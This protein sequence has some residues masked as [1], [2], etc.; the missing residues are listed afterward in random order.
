MCELTGYSPQKDVFAI[1]LA[2]HHPRINLLGISTVFGNASLEYV[3]RRKRESAFWLDARCLMLDAT[4]I[5]RT[6][7]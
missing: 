3:R 5:W 2:A 1:L 4:S 6:R 7:S